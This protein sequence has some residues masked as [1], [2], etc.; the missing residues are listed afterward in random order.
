M[1]SRPVLVYADAKGNI[2]D[3]PELEMAG[4]SAGRWHRVSPRDWIPLP[5]GSELFLLPERLPVGYHSRS[6]TFRVL[7]HDPYESA[8]PVQA[9][10]AFAAPAHTQTYCAA[11]QKLPGA[12]LL[13][14]FAYTAV[15]WQR[16]RF[17]VAA[18]RVDPDERQDF[19]HFDLARID[20]NARRRMAQQSTNRLMQHLGKCALTYGCPAARNL[21]LDRWEAPLPTSPDCNARCLGCIS[22]QDHPGLCATQDRITFVPTAE[23]IVAIAGPHLQ[24]APG[25]LVSFG[26]GCEGEPLLQA[27]TLQQAIVLMR[28]TTRRG[29]IN[30]NTNASLPRAVEKLRRAGLDSMRVSLNSCQ[31]QFYGAYYR[32]RGY[33]F[34]DVMQS[35]RIMKASAGFVSLNYFVLPGFTDDLEEWNS[36]RRLIDATGIDLIQLRNLNIDPEW[37]LS[38]LDFR[39]HGKPIGISR[40]IEKLRTE[41]P[42]VRLGYF[43]PP[44]NSAEH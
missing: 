43:N 35:V 11:Y 15:G 6:K 26:Q 17:V 10:A 9:V 41:F 22:R 19:R 36:L 16:D 14:L 42:R 23:E 29:T 39:P 4:S 3:F 18:R 8:K 13:P 12:K 30:L 21:F 31:P 28:E 33:T 32:P 27:K 44:L 25:A 1:S 40:L 24:N 5:E 7:S 2:F 37:Y 34:D 38:S 20:K